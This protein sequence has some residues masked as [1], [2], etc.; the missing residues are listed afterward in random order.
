MKENLYKL[1]GV[2]NSLKYP[3][4][5]FVSVKSIFN[6]EVLDNKTHLY[7]AA[8]WLLYMQNSDGGY[9]RKFS[10]LN[11]G[12]DKSY[13]ETTGYIIET[14]LKFDIE[15][16]INSALKAGE[17][18]LSIQNKDGSFSE[19]DTNK[20]FVFDTGQVLIGVNSLYKFT[21]EEKYKNAIKK[22]GEWLVKVQEEDGSWEKYAYNQQKHT[23][24]TRVSA[25][26]YEAGE[27]LENEKF[28]EC[29]LKNINWVLENQKDN[30]FFKYASFLEGVPAYLHTIIYILEGL[31]EVYKKTKDEKILKAILKNA[32]KLKEVGF[33]RDLILC[34]QYDENFNCVNKE[35]CITGLAQWA[36]VAVRIYEITKDVS[37]LQSASI[38]LFY[39]KAKQIKSSFMKGGF[40]ASMPFWGRYGGF[41]FVNWSNKFFI[42]ALLLYQKHSFSKIKE[43]ELFVSNAFRISDEV[44]TETLSI[45]DNKYIICF[46]KYIKD[47]N[48]KVLD[49]GCGRGVI[50]N[51][52]SKSYKNIEFFGIDPVFESENIKKG[53]IYSIEGK[54]DVIMAF[55]VLQHT[56]IDEAL[57]SIYNALNHNG[58]IIIGERN[59][60][61]ILGILKP[62]YELKGKWMYPFDSPFREKWNSIK[63]WRNLLKRHGFE[64][65]HICYLDN[66]FDKVSKTNRYFFIVGEKI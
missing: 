31:I 42:D 9:A 48:K 63:E 30:G 41:D 7:L 61:S 38:T 66:E 29:A 46:K 24:Y 20:P 62:I 6:E 51:E 27:I 28:K 4:E 3:K 64:I 33:Y 25:A 12:R 19:I 10:F 14:L 56:Y 43:Q 21:K 44:V 58:K 16:Y 45:M 32:N 49:V 60:F 36:G 35:K 34:S 26:L 37:F 15:K 52:L 17:W 59:P 39:L 1:Y 22:A 8:D 2:L 55:E 65:K 5:L 57:N 50:I 11:N 18:L 53:S 23:Y 54:F 47:E 40:S 13:I